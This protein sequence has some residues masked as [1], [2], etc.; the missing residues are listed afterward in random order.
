MDQ[1]S[2]WLP[3]VLDVATEA[4]KAG[5]EQLKKYW[6]NISNLRQK[7]FSSDL[8][9]EADEKSEQAILKVLTHYFSTHHILSE[10]AGANE[11]S[12]SFSWGIDPLD[13]TTNYAHHY[14]VF[15]ISIGLLYQGQPILGVIYHPIAEEMFTAYQ[16][17]GAYLNGE[18]IKVSKTKE[19]DKSLLAT[20]FA[21]DRAS[22]E[23]NNYAEFSHLTNLTHGVRRGGSAALDLAYVACGRLDGYWESGIKIWDIAAGVALIQEAGGKVSDYDLSALDYYSG[24]IL[25]S[26]SLLQKR[27][28][29]S[30]F[31]KN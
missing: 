23:D 12:S 11:I 27:L 19:L 25:A 17:G 3:S 13:G 14:P 10:E 7:S 16:G 20:G 5:A 24:R 2:Q 22:R 30:L 21:Y 26:N 18:K 4:A 8:V 31:N 15:A 1:L 28:S 6:R 29:E 9:T